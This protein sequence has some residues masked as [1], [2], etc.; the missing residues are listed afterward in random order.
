[1]DIMKE[2]GLTKEDFDKLYD[3][4]EGFNTRFHT[5]HS[6]RKDGESVYSYLQKGAEGLVSEDIFQKALFN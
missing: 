4:N 2:I 3:L 5:S 1:M 6:L